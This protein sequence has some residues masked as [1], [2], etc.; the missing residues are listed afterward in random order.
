MIPPEIS[1]HDR[2]AATGSHGR[3]VRIATT[4]AIRVDRE[5]F[6]RQRDRISSPRVFPP[7][8]HS[9]L[10]L[11][12]DRILD[13]RDK[14][15]HMSLSLAELVAAALEEDLGEDRR[16][17]TTEATIPPG[18]SADALIQQ[19]QPGVIYGLEAV[20]EVFRQLDP[21]VELQTLCREAEWREGGEVMRLSGN[22]AS[23]LK[24]ERTA[25][26]LLG[27][28][29]GI[30]TLT[31]RCVREVE[32]TGVTLL[33]TRKTTP[34][35][36]MLEKQA[37]AA[38]GARN[39]RLGLHDAI[40]I[41]ENH[42]AVAGGVKPAIEAARRTHPGL[43]VKVEV[44]NMQELQDALAAGADQI[45]LDNMDPDMVRDAV[46]VVAGRAKL[47]A[48]GGITFENLREYATTGVDYI[49]LGFITHSAPCLD[50][51]LL[52]DI[53]T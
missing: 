18:A 28:L 8:A 21:E 17:L 27:H 52:V 37:V 35:Y 40:L 24:G 38:G 11:R 6:H 50:V 13:R 29:S 2:L 23:I 22:A 19:K 15:N 45:L 53:T 47:E 10:F 5:A 36:R 16:D 48:S 46:W 1:S 7:R 51:S 31:A 9:P 12:I 41:K 43:P 33:D 49:S 34:G 14:V 4:F 42:L 26:N 39:H 3:P 30:A 25:L 32:G 44:Q 20:R